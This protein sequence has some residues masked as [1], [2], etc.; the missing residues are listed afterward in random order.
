MRVVLHIGTEKTATTTLQD[1]VYANREVLRQKGVVLS[2]VLGKTNNRKLAAFCVPE[3]NFDDYFKDRRIRT[4]E[5][6]R[7]HFQGFRDSFIS[8]ARQL[9]RTAHTL[10]I[11]S[12][13]FHSRLRDTAS[14]ERLKAVLDEISDDVTVLCYF[15]EQSAVVYSLYSTAI[16]SGNVLDL[17]AYAAR[18]VPKN[19]Y[20]N[21]FR[22]F[23]KWR[24]VFGRERLRARL[25]AKNA[26]VG[27]DIRQD[28]LSQ[29]LPEPD[30]ADFDCTAPAANRS[31]GLVGLELGRL[32]NSAFGRYN[33]DGTMNPVRQRLLD[34]IMHSDLGRLGR[35]PFPQA[36][37]IHKRFARSN[38]RFA[39]E[40][41]DLRRN[42]F[43]RPGSGE[44]HDAANAP[45]SP[46]ALAQLVDFWGELLEMIHRGD[47]GGDTRAAQLAWSAATALRTSGSM[48]SDRMRLPPLKVDP[49][50]ERLSFARRIRAAIAAARLVWRS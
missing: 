42:P 2:D 15:R 45:L 41:L 28:L 14:I 50:A 17:T 26:F 16:K 9:S 27:G 10:L 29:L 35:L 33:A 1:F 36:V 30:M 25:Y 34:L 22:F 13:H 48:S 38:R 11:T 7:A 32:T 49:S 31:L 4:V 43:P 46:T 19:D 44:D 40:Y 21:Y 37:E 5:A 3:K 20:F 18:C 23:G 24:D 47:L 8:E 39:V 12:E 6:K